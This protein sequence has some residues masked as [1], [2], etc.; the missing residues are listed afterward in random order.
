M[1]PLVG[2]NGDADPMPMT[3]LMLVGYLLSELVCR[4]LLRKENAS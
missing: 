1:M 2:I 4:T 3:I